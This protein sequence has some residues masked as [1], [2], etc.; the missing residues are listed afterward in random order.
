MSPRKWPS[1]PSTTKAS[2]SVVSS[3]TTAVEAYRRV[4]SI[5]AVRKSSAS[6]DGSIGRYTRSAIVT[7]DHSMAPRVFVFVPTGTA[8]SGIRVARSTPSVPASAA[9]SPSGRRISPRPRSG[10]KQPERATVPET[11][12]STASKTSGRYCTGGRLNA[13]I[14]PG[15]AHSNRRSQDTEG[16]SV[17]SSP[18]ARRDAGRRV[19]PSGN[20]AE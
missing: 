6:R 19:A 10:R 15:P 1:R 17:Y 3:A 7:C 13:A 14:Q 5:R 2:G 4:E 9:H 18:P 20:Y 16:P 8:S 12:D 11:E